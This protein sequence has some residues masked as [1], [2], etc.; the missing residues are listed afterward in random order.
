MSDVRRYLARIGRRGGI[1]SRR[2]LAPDVAREM[3]RAREARRATRR[4][5]ATHLHSGGGIFPADTTLVAGETQDALLRRL[6]ASQKLRRVAELS[7][8]VDSLA[9]AGVAL[10]HPDADDRELDYQSAVL[11]LGAV[12]ADRAYGRR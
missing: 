3:V 9:R 12:L 6:S 4:R 8:M 10:R 2:A 7:R 1:K 5:I 11:R